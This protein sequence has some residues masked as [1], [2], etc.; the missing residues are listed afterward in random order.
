[1]KSSA[2]RQED[3]VVRDTKTSDELIDSTRD[4]PTSP[5]QLRAQRRSFV[6]PCTA[7]AI[8]DIARVIIVRVGTDFER[9]FGSE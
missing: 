3:Q 4:A 1:L 9:I 6:F 5:E 2:K 7:I 8:P